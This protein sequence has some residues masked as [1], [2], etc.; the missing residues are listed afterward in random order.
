MK[1][2]LEWLKSLVAVPWSAEATAEKLADLGFPVE[3]IARTGFKARGV[4]S[5]RINAVEKHPNADRLRIAHVFDGMEERTVVCGAPNIA[6]G[7]VV[8]LA[9]PGAKVQGGLEILVSKIRGVESHGMLCSER[10]LGLSDEHAGIVQLPREMALGTDLKK[11]FGEDVVLD[12]EVPPNRPDILSHIGVGRELA[13]VSGQTLKKETLSSIKPTKGKPAQDSFSCPIRIEAPKLCHRY[14]GRVIRDVKVGPSPDWMAKR[15]KACGIR[16]INNIVDITNYVLLEWGHPLHAFDLA[17]LKGPAIIVRLAKEKESFMALDGKIYSL[18]SSDLVIADQER[19]V[20]IAGVMGGEETGVTEKTVD[21]LLE[22]AVFDRANIRQASKRL[23]LKTESSIR[24]EKGTDPE[25]AQQASLRATE[26]ILNLAGGSA[27]ALIDVYPQKRKPQ[28]IT[29]LSSRLN[30]LSGEDLPTAQVTAILKRLQLNPVKTK[31]GWTCTVPAFRKDLL[32]DADVIEDV[33][34]V[35]GYSTSPSSIGQIRPSAIPPE[36]ALKAKDHTPLIE[37]LRGVG[38]NETMT[39]S[40]SSISL[41]KAFGVREQEVIALANPIS[42]EESVLR[43]LLIP[44]LLEAVK[45]NIHRQREAVGLF[46]RGPVFSEESG[47]T[48]FSQKENAA[49]VLYGFMTEKTWLTP[50][51]TVDFFALK[52]I[53]EEMNRSLNTGFLFEFGSSLPF[54]HP[55][56]S[57]QLKVNDRFVG[58]GGTLH[59]SLSVL[60]DIKHPVVVA[61]FDL[62][63]RGKPSSQISEESKFPAVERDVAIIVDA[64]LSWESIEKAVRQ[65]GGGLMRKIVPFDIFSGGPVEAGKKSVAFRIRLQAM[66]RT[67]AET[68]INSF[69]DNIKRSLKERFGAQPR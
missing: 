52:G 65:T 22:S 32:A 46:E 50:A 10:E 64:G 19:P 21:V 60:F 2:S 3:S 31:G 41:L 4:V 58:W 18:S 44:G 48:S 67:L 57:F 8:P 13:A 37:F 29:L 15:L 39:S 56:Q 66:D 11:W 68:E 38:L 7:Q 47:S 53:F 5:A 24:F 30:R 54:L 49:L 27:G 61:E 55:K 36:L 12:L 14:L 45:R 23:G 69:V 20:A 6:P 42:Q 25:T 16:P 59:P 63:A 35:K 28:K 9:L 26:L 51:R 33:L 34:R 62:L 17:C 1:V 43:P 40:F